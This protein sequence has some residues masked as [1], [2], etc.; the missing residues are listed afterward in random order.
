MIYGNL[1]LKKKKRGTTMTEIKRWFHS[2]LSKM[3][4]TL[5]YSGNTY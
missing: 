2:K 5:D 3:Q 4:K 1:S